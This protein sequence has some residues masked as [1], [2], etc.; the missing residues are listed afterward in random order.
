MVSAE[1][2]GDSFHNPWGIGNK[3][4]SGKS[5]PRTP[6]NRQESV[7]RL[8]DEACRVFVEQSRECH[9][10]L[11]KEGE[12]VYV[13]PSIE[14]MLG[15]TSEEYA[16]RTIPENIHPDDIEKVWRLLETQVRIP[17]ESVTIVARCLHK[18]GSWHYIEGTGTNLIDNPAIG[19]ILINCRDVTERVV[20]EE[21]LRKAYMEMERRVAERTAQLEIFNRRLRQKIEDYQRTELALRESEAKHRTLLEASPDAVFLETLEGKILDCNDRACQMYGYS[22]EDMLRLGVADIVPGDVARPLPEMIQ[23]HLR[24]GGIHLETRAVRKGGEAFPV[25]VST[26]L[27]NLE[28]RQLVVA[29]VRDITARPRAAEALKE[30]VERE[31]AILEATTDIVFLI[32]TE[33]RLLAFNDVFARVVNR[34]AETLPGVCVYDVLNLDAARCRRAQV[35]EALASGKP[36]RVEDQSLGRWYAH[37]VFPTFDETGKIARLAVFARDITDK[38]L[39][40]EALREAEARYRL[41]IENMQEG[42]WLLNDQGVI[43][44]ANTHIAQMLGYAA[45]EMLGKPL[46]HFTDSPDLGGVPGMLERRRAGIAEEYETRFR[47]KDGATIH[48]HIRSLPFRDAEGRFVGV[49]GCVRDVT[50]QRKLEHRILMISEEERQSLGRDLHD[51]LAQYMTAI[52]MR[53]DVLMSHLKK[54]GLP[55]IAA[56]AD[57]SKLIDEANDEVRA[58]IKG[59]FPGDLVRGDLP[60]ALKLLAAS[61]QAKFGIPCDV[62]TE[63][64]LPALDYAIAVH[65]YR[66]AQEATNNAGKYSQGSRLVIELSAD[67]H[68]LKMRVTDNGVGIP[69]EGKDR[70]GMGLKIMGYRARSIGGRFDIGPAD[71]G[72]TTV[73]VT[74]PL[75]NCAKRPA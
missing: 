39:A 43:T 30:S 8:S 71:G 15:Y 16:K 42:I 11:S 19:G 57:I 7:F 73:T 36:S 55:E 53:F 12:V 38:K 72:G 3:M 74:V 69:A 59:L 4:K 44:F 5:R 1:L 10:V 31:R 47:R 34:E 35:E 67:E 40:E 66:I 64:P 2:C 28:G 63:G 56:A 75:I 51:G 14:P 24:N 45:E 62:R 23:E 33:G 6:R 9:I 65:L 60:M 58:L 26:R 52:G 13:S 41:L 17:S 68:N 46:A 25:E 61:Q 27:V 32:D 48:V 49:L 54:D 20:A 70:E 29:Y 37:R 21:A 22:R 18:D 50:E